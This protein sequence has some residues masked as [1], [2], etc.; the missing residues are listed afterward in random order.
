M[1]NLLIIDNIQLDKQKL[2][3][4]V[5]SFHISAIKIIDLDKMQNDI[6]ILLNSSNTL[7]IKEYVNNL[8]KYDTS[9]SDKVYLK[10][11]C[12]S[13]IICTTSLLNRENENFNILLYNNNLSWNK[14]LNLETSIDAANLIENLLTYVSKYLLNKT[15]KYSIIAEQIKKFIKKNYLSNININ[16]IA[17]KF[18]YSPNYI[19]YVF[20][21]TFGQ[22]ISDY[23]M[24][25]KIL[26]SKELLMDI[27]NK[28]Y[29][30]SESLGFSNASYFCS[31]FK[32]HTSLTPKEYRAN[33]I[34]K[35]I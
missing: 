11:L 27:N 13:I 8:F 15:N 5:D 24:V 30:I 26:K 10:N 6:N 17:D 14:L 35:D 1:C 2:K 21:K 33:N 29:N 31:V 16:S 34:L 4:I 23:I 12:F 25:L 32:K 19:S 9:I 7:E 18:N 22:N 3:N 20:K 28:I